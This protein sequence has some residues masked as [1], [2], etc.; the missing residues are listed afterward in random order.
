MKNNII[1]LEKLL[2]VILFC[3]AIQNVA[4]CQDDDYDYEDTRKGLTFGLGAGFGYS[5]HAEGYKVEEQ[6]R[7]KGFSG[8]RG[9]VVDSKL[10]WRVSNRLE[11]YST[12]Q[13]S[14]SNTT[15]S[16]Y[17]SFFYGGAAAY[18]FKNHP[19]LSLHAGFGRYQSHLKK[20]GPCGDGNLVNTGISLQVSDNFFFDLKM[21]AGKMNKANLDRNPFGSTELNF[22]FLAAYK[23]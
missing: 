11:I 12:V 18:Y 21:L 19:N 9:I 7:T 15:I 14:P 23:Y 2:L 16:P 10:G 6:F 4:T 8:L 3:I 20:I 22:S 1:L 13:F 17:K 5:V